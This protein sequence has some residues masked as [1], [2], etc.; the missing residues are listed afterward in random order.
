MASLGQRHWFRIATH[1]ALAL[2]GFW[3]GRHLFP[4]LS[5]SGILPRGQHSS[6]GSQS[7]GSAV[8][9]GHPKPAP[10]GIR[11]NSRDS[12]RDSDWEALLQTAQGG[13]SD[14]ILTRLRALH[15]EPDLSRQILGQQLLIGRLAEI[16]PQRALAEAA[17]LGGTHERAMA[18]TVVMARWA[19]T[20]PVAAADYL[21]EN[22]ASFGMLDAHQRR[23]T[24]AVAGAWAGSDPT[25]AA[26]WAL[27]QPVESRGD[28]LDAVVRRVAASDPERAT[29][30]L[31]RLPEGFERT[32]LVR[33]MVGFLAASNPDTMA[34]WSLRLPGDSERIT[35]TA[36]AVQSWSNQDPESAAQWVSALPEGRVRDAAIASL[37]TGSPFLQSPETSA[38][39]IEQIGDEDLRL[40]ARQSLDFRWRTLDPDTHPSSGDGSERP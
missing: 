31:N 36:W 7:T 4:D 3:I 30:I 40:S 5:G 8:A 24:G 28:A 6:P 16:A 20:D 13:D 15:R 10:V 21:A 26:E 14:E 12:G 22:S 19:S 35:A 17:A 9:V 18:E 29:E 2:A 1:L 23:I 33:S 39:W 34:A 11:S 25:A 38:A 32:E 27:A 37:I